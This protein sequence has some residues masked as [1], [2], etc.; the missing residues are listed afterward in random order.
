[1]N[2]TGYHKMPIYSHR[3]IDFVD[4][5]IDGDVPL[6][7]DPERVAFSSHPYDE[8]GRIDE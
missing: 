8:M 1:M 6:Y 7:I 3:N 4:T 2:F 5:L